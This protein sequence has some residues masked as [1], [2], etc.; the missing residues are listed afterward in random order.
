L[1]TSCINSSCQQNYW[2]LLAES[3][4]KRGKKCLSKTV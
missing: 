1:I 2:S 4:K 3:R